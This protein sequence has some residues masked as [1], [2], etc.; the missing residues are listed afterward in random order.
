M[1]ILNVTIKREK[2]VKYLGINIDEKLNWNS[3]IDS[4][5]NSLLKY[6]GIFNQVKGYITRI[7]ARQLYFAFIYSRIAYGIEVYGSCSKVNMNKLQVL[8][9]KLIKLLLNYD[10]RTDTNVIHKNLNIMKVQDIQNAN[11]IHFVNNCLLGRYPPP[12]DSYYSYNDTPYNLREAKLIA[13]RPRTTFGAQ[14]LHI[15]GAKLW[16]STSNEIKVHRNKLNFKKH[17]T[18]SYISKYVVT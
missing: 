18:R 10:Y 1:T 15:L 3:H 5:C 17:I 8:Q 12:F 9:N 16:N 2:V 6:F 4:V 11:I 13:P 7:L 14:N